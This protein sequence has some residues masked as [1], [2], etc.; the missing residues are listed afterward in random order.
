VKNEGHEVLFL[1]ETKLDS[2]GM[3]RIRIILGFSCAFTV[4][5]RGSRGGL[6]MLW[7]AGIQL[8]IQN[9]SYHHI[10]SCIFGTKNKVW[11]L[12]GFYGWPEDQRRWESWALLDHLH[13]MGE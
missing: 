3:E 6:A 7:K 13:G 12:T 4:P 8:E 1:M 2:V 10:D 11:R 5:S 9:Y